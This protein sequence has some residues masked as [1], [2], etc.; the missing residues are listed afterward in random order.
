MSKKTNF[1]VLLTLLFFI[2]LCVVI[3]SPINN[4]VFANAQENQ[5][6]NKLNQTVLDQ[7]GAL[8]LK[9][10]EKYLQSLDKFKDTT[11]A[12]RLMAYIKG[13]GFAYQDFQKDITKILFEKVGELLPFFACIAAIAILSGIMSTLKSG[14][15]GKTSAEMIYFIS[16]TATLIPL[17]AVL[18]ECFTKTR[19]S[20]SSMQTQMQLVFPIMLT[21]MAASGGAVSVQIAKPAVAFFSDFIVSAISSIVLPFTVTI[22]AFSIAANLSKELKI[23]KFTAFFKSI[24]KWIIGICSLEINMSRKIYNRRRVSTHIDKAISAADVNVF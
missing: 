23:S 20:I 19:T 5:A 18:T 15:A 24:N 3:F 17:I 2:H 9:A 12:E 21:L 16:Y 8:D 7:I 4:V 13:E 10:L 1:R 11:I 14:T 22:I 6:E